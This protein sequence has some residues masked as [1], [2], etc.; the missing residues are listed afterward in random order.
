MESS[1]D[2]LLDQSQ[3]VK[4]MP[5]NQTWENN[6]I[7]TTPSFM[8]SYNMSMNTNAT[9]NMNLNTTM[10]MEYM[11]NNMQPG[12]GIDDNWNAFIDE[13]PEYASLDP[14]VWSHFLCARQ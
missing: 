6:N 5:W 13:H 12:Q 14:T 1:D 4:Y 2:G 9:T 11:Y 3:E 8:P 10:N 7:N